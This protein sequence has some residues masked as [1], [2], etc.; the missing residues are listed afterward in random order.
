MATAETSFLH[1]QV[2]E[3]K[4]RLEAVILAT[5]DEENVRGL[6]REVDSALDKFAAG[7]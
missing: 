2:E 6:L 4:R 5:P 7:T 3:R 1:G